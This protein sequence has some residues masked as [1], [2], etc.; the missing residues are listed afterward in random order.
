L[1]PVVV[2][3]AYSSILH[4]LL[5]ELAAI[6]FLLLLEVLAHKGRREL[7]DRKDHKV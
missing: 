5:Q 4:L 7:Q 2:T 6:Y 3:E 1:K